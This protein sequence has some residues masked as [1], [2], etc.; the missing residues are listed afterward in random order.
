LLKVRLGSSRSSTTMVALARYHA[1]YKRVGTAYLLAIFLGGVGAHHYYLGHWVIGL[2]YTL[3]FMVLVPVHILTLGLSTLVFP[4]LVLLIEL[5]FLAG[6][7]RRHNQRLEE[8]TTESLGEGP[9]VDEAVAGMPRRLEPTTESADGELDDR[10]SSRVAGIFGVLVV[11]IIVGVL[12][13][14]WWQDWRET[15]GSGST[16]E[17]RTGSQ[18]PVIPPQADQPEGGSP[19]PLGPSVEVS[20]ARLRSLGFASGVSAGH[21]WSK[22]S[23]DGTAHVTVR[24]YADQEIPT[25]EIIE[26]RPRTEQEL[27]PRAEE[28]L[29]VSVQVLRVLTEAGGPE[30]EVLDR[31]VRALVQCIALPRSLDAERLPS[32]Q[33]V[34]ADETVQIGSRLWRLQVK[35]DWTSEAARRHHT[36]TEYLTWSES[37]RREGDWRSCPRPDESVPAGIVHKVA[38][39]P[40]RPQ[41][42]RTPSISAQSAS[43]GPREVTITV[44][45]AHVVLEPGYYGGKT[46]VAAIDITINRGSEGDDLVSLNSLNFHF[47]A[48]TGVAYPGRWYVGLKGICSHEL[49]LAPNGSIS[50]TAYFESVDGYFENLHGSING[51]LMFQA[52]P[53]GARVRVPVRLIAGGDQ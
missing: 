19:V 36:V 10:S 20:G 52:R 38:T 40:V 4:G 2:L 41:P 13:V 37:S 53:L 12:F 11:L 15:R 45:R 42:P 18:G 44:G 3:V 28:A 14:G 22:A 35:T 8:E 1:E 17:R 48:P 27:E 6:R 31:T 29:A 5:P 34:S 25:I 46:R 26:V 30:A 33:S 39:P 9:L 23:A 21:E 50:C 16:G 51:E 47:V 43:P 49:A 32:A 24:L 7:V